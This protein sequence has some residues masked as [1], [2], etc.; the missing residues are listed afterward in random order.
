MGGPIAF[1]VL[2]GVLFAMGALFA[3]GWILPDDVARGVGCI[4]A[5][6]LMLVLST[7]PVGPVA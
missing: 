1:R 5:G 6:L 3:F 7:V 2:A 4:A